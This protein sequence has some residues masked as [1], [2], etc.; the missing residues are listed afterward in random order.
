MLGRIMRAVRAW[1][2]GMVLLA[3]ALVSCASEPAPWL[4]NQSDIDPCENVSCGP[5]S[6]CVPGAGPGSGVCE[7]ERGLPSRF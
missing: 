5:G 1:V 7:S 6:H 3:A 2:V 4:R